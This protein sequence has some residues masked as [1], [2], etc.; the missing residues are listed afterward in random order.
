MMTLPQDDQDARSRLR[1]HKLA[2]YAL[3]AGAAMAWDQ[4]ADAGVVYSGVRDEMLAYSP[5]GASLNLSLVGPTV[6]F[7]F[8]DFPSSSNRLLGMFGRNNG[9]PYNAEV[10]GRFGL[11]SLNAGD[12]I[13]PSQTFAS[14]FHPTPRPSYTVGLLAASSSGSQFGPFLGAQGK[15]VGLRFQIP[16]D[17]STHYGWARI[18]VD[19]NFDLTLTDWAYESTRPTKKSSQE[20]P[21]C[22]P[23][24]NRR[25]SACWP[26]VRLRRAQ[27]RF[28]VDSSLSRDK[29]IPSNIRCELARL[30]H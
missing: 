18:S 9:S 16:A 15:F 8:E 12:P 19:A 10:V 17:N 1:K 4:Q 13:G 30:V 25:R 29:T 27:S 5:A 20:I 2:G 24:L 28:V 22:R 3:A 23:F 6:D 7:T 21:V 14:E 26:W 11:T